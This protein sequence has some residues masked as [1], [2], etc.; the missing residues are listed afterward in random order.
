MVALTI[1]ALSLV[2]A[3]DARPNI[4]LILADDLGYGSLGAYG[5]KEIPTPNIDSIAK[6]G[7]KMTDGY[8]SCPICAPTRAG[9]MTGRYQQRFGFEHNP[10]PE[11]QA[12]DKFGLPIAETTIAEVLK[13]NGYRTGMFGK[14]HLGYKPELQPTARGFDE[15]FGFLS[16]ARSYFRSPRTDAILRGTKEVTET[17]YLTDALAREAVAFMGQKSDKPFF[18][19]LPFNAVH[20]PME[21]SAKYTES[22]TELTGT[23]KTFAGMQ[24]GLDVAVGKVLDAIKEKGIE[25]NTV[26][27]FLSDN[28]GPTQQTTSSNKPLRGVK[29]QMYEGGIRVPFMVQWQGKVKPGTVVNDPCFSLDI[30]PTVLEIAGVSKEDKKEKLDGRSLMPVLQGSQSAKSPR[31][32]FWRMGAQY[33]VRSGDWKMV[34]TRGR[35]ELFN[36]KSDIAEANNLSEKEPQKLKELQALFAAWNKE[37]IPPIWRRSDGS[38]GD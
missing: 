21:A 22:F 26:V 24:A 6:N 32:I 15:F 31:A 10:G 17:E 3:I 19:Y 2:S 28:G 14:W 1:A 34:S 13:K 36:L 23:R 30:F 38:A 35:V 29:G 4:V 9:L 37:N 5:E 12:N 25:K 8:V 11:R 18:V 33:A 27:F 16:G 20:A 7:A